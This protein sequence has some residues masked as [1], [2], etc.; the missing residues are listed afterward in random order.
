MANLLELA[1]LSSAVYETADLKKKASVNVKGHGS[2][3]VQAL[4]LQVDQ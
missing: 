3:S 1:Q 2:G 4:N